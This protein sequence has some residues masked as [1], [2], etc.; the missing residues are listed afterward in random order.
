MSVVPAPTVRVPLIVVLPRP[1][2]MAPDT[3]V[4]TWRNVGPDAAE[5]AIVCAPASEN[6]TVVFVEK[7]I[8]RS[9]STVDWHRKVRAPLLA[10]IVTVPPVPPEPISPATV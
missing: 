10:V 1:I 5:P 6:S 9:K 4:L 7:T 8:G 3:D 2:V